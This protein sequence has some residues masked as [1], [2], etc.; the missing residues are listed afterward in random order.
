M[1]T[2]HFFLTLDASESKLLAGLD[3]FKG[4][5]LNFMMI[6][7]SSGARFLADVS[8]FN[9]VRF[10]SMSEP[11]FLV[12]RFTQSEKEWKKNNMLEQFG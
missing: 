5:C 7:D 10:F 2:G 8:V 9:D 11:R 6:T 3:I 12:L 4:V 1:Y